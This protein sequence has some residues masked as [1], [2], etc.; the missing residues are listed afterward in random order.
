AQILEEVI[1]SAASVLRRALAR[2]GGEDRLTLPQ[3]RCLQ[4]IAATG[5]ALT[6]QLARQMEVTVPTMTGRIDGLVTRGFVERQPDPLDRRQ[7]RLVLTATGREHF[8]RC[9]QA[10]ID[11]LQRLLA[12]LSADQQARLTAALQDLSLLLADGRRKASARQAG[13]TLS[14]E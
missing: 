5:S 7:I 13:S 4:A 14:P 10:I 2:V 9:Q 1:N 6:T 3:Y 11:E 8:E 12:P